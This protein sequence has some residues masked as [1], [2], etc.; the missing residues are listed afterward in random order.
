MSNASDLS[1][2]PYPQASS[3][4]PQTVV[5][6][7]LLGLLVLGVIIISPYGGWKQSVLFLIGGLF[8]LSLYHASFGFASAYRKLF[9]YRDAN[10]VLAQILMLAIATLIFAPFLLAGTVFGQD[11]RGAVAPVGVQGAIGA[12]LFGIGMQLGS[13]CACGTLYTIGGGSSMMLLTLLTFGIGSF[14]ASLTVALWEGL[15]KFEPISLVQAWGW[16]GVGLQLLVSGAIALFLRQLGNSASSPNSELTPLEASPFK[17]L[18]Y[19]PWSLIFGAIALAV[20]NWLTL[21]LAGR[22]WGV[23]WG[24]TL[25]AAKIAQGLGW[26]PATSEF[27]SSGVG[28][29]ALSESVFADIT[30]VMNFGIVLGAALAAAL[31]GRLA[32]KKPA[33]KA[34]IASALI[35]GLMMGYGARLAFG[36]NVGAYFSGI[37][38]TSLH[39]WLWIAFALVGTILGIRLRSLFRLAN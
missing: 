11:L 1:L 35:G 37:A 12:F 24:F 13:G 22:P 18:L 20:L 33:S 3:P 17:R 8:G 15:P 14:W 30:S 27:W 10:G 26:N 36:C 32:V 4:R 21:L 16:W 7:V 29:K 28:A 39:G 2:S 23:T 6:A 19:G 25:W 5:I 31:A 38:S 9:V 34:A